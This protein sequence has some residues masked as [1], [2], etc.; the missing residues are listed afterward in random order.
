SLRARAAVTKGGHA[1][2]D[3]D[4]VVSAIESAISTIEG[5]QHG[6]DRADAVSALVDLGLIIGEAYRLGD[7]DPE[8]VEKLRTW[9]HRMTG[10]LNGLKASGDF[11]SVGVSVGF[12]IPSVA[13][14]VNW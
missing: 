11:S 4:A 8:R 10:A 3:Y 13:I 6:V 12:P 2:S 9:I 14:S 1:M 7:K 5:W